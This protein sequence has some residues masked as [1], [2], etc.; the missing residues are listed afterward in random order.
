M[1][2]N[3]YSVAIIDPSEVFRRGVDQIIAETSLFHTDMLMS[4]LPANSSNMVDIVIVNPSVSTPSAIKQI[5]PNA[6]LVATLYNYIDQNILRQFDDVIELN[7]SSDKILQTLERCIEV[8]KVSRSTMSDVEELSDR[9]REILVA[10]AKG[11]LNK[12]IAD[13]FNISIHTVIAHRK[14][15]S[16]KTAIRSVSGLVVYALLN[17]LIT[18]SEILM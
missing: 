9:E 13:H 14:N 1:S 2:K 3:R 12:E 10:V 11:M 15:I 18:E 5:F 8:N 7:D 16:R 6:K 4:E 17:N